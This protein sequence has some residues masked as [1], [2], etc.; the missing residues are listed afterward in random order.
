MSVLRSGWIVGAVVLGFAVVLVPPALLFWT[1]IQP[2][3]LNAG[4]VRIR[5][6][7]VR[8]E[9]GGL[10]FLYSVQNLTQH[11]A[12]FS[13]DS[14]RIRALQ[15]ADRPLVGYANLKLPLDLPAASAHPVEVRLELPGAKMSM[16]GE[17]SDE[18][19]WM[20]L[21]QR[22]PMA[23]PENEPPVSPLPMRGKLA[24]ND[25]PPPAPAA[26][27]FEDFLGD[28]QGFELTDPVRGIKLHFPRGW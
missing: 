1:S 21:R 24:A 28:L 26:F 14:T 19:T 10:V 4:T 2:E 5:F 7:S 8:Y 6:Q 20:V 17:Q 12:R 27:S 16:A 15:T 13:P 3:P 9:A 23:P 25:T 11:R 18:H 22:I